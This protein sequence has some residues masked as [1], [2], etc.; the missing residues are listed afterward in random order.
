M[1][2]S[3]AHFLQSIAKKD[4]DATLVS[5]DKA[6][7]VAEVETNIALEALDI[8]SLELYEPG[9]SPIDSSLLRDDA[10]ENPSDI[11]VRVIF[12]IFAVASILNLTTLIL[13][14][15]PYW[16]LLFDE[17][18]QV[19][20]IVFS[21]TLTLC[22]TFFCLMTWQRKT[23]LG[24]IFACAWAFTRLFTL[25]SLSAL[26]TNIVPVFMDGLFFGQ[27]V[28]IVLYT[29][30]R[31]KFTDVGDYKY[32]RDATIAMAIASVLVWCI[33]IYIFIEENAWL[34][35]AI[36]FVLSA[37]A[38]AYN[39][40]TIKDLILNDSKYNLFR[41]DRELAAIEYYSKVLILVWNKLSGV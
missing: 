18:R 36:S 7:G 31:P 20:I 12:G 40:W 16:L 38:C 26:V 35:G 1:S 8:E 6:S 29:Y 14:F 27:S 24:L 32:V 22:A 23:S 4:E 25:G 30:F 17:T 41:K 39:W 37:G 21:I 9:Q 2:Y 15:V 19:A 13:G 33:G 3:E 28:T 34:Y 11:V 10:T 5:F